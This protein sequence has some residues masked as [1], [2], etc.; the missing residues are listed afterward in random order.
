MEG[1]ILIKS[2]AV[3]YR[4]SG[5]SPEEFSQYWK[6][7]HAP[8]AARVIPGMRKYVQNH[9]IKLPGRE[10]EGDGIVEMWWDDL[11][12]FRNFGEWVITDA[13][14]PLRDDGDKFTDMSKSR[15]WLV[16]EHVIKE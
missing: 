8:L 10:Y 2:I 12:A 13:G 14:K 5:I 15:L 6:D 16:E 3:A 9:L 4:K 11:A 7:I 1:N